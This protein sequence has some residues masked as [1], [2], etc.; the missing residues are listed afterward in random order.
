MSKIDSALLNI[1]YIDTLSYQ[2]TVIHRL[3]P[4]AKLLTT[5]VFIVTVVSFGK[6]EISAMLPFIIYPVFLINLGNLPYLYFLKRLLL[7]SPF[8]LLIGIFNPLL[9]R[10]IF[11]YVGPIGVSG[12]WISFISIIIRFILSVGAALVLIASTGFIP[13]CLAAKKLGAPKIFVIQLL[14]LYRYLFVLIQEALRMAR[15]RSLRSFN[16]KGMGI[17]AFSSLIGHLL[18]RTLDRSQRIHIAMLCRGFD[19]EIR[20]K[21]K[22]KFGLNEIVFT[23]GFT[24]FFALA[25]LYNIPQLFGAWITGIHL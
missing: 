6:H 13:V 25:R 9:E 24:I 17:R 1:G 14:F 15:A 23:L 5:L 18:L 3:D 21:H 12:G 22:L 2:D 11:V 10:E 20:I 8:V 4:R 19:G 16:G 7:V